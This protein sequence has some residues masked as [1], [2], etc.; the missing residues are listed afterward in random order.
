[1]SAVLPDTAAAPSTS[2]RPA[3]ATPSAAAST[4][5]VDDKPKTVTS[6]IERLALSREQLRAAMLPKPKAAKDG[7]SGGI[8]AMA[9]HLTDRVKEVPGV[10]ILIDALKT[11]WARHPLHTAGLVAAEASRKFA[12][13]IAERRPMTLILSA[14]L[15]GAVLAL[16]RPWRWLLRPALFAGLLPALVSRAMKELPVDSLIR[17]F[18]SAPARTAAKTPGTF[19][20][21]PL[22]AV[23]PTGT[24]TAAQTA[25]P[26]SAPSQAA[27]VPAGEFSVPPPARAGADGAWSA[28][29]TT[30]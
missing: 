28:T 24:P 2:A 6:A 11:W 19:T 5:A 15:L 27:A 17:M 23:A 26:V 21:A 22:S 30:H 12:G 14:V 18:G 8:A 10:P 9:S 16:T 13:P 7:Q 3:A 29:A 20:S 4:A 1:M 25:A